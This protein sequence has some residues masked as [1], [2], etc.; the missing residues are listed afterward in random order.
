MATPVAAAAA[1]TATGKARVRGRGCLKRIK[2][3]STLRP[4]AARLSSAAAARTATVYARRDETSLKAN[5][6]T[7]GLAAALQPAV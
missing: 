6:R 7:N 5:A 1:A 4:R 3:T 2:S